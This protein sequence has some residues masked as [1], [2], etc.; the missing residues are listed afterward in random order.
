LQSRIPQNS[1]KAF[2]APVEV[3]QVKLQLD[4][5]GRSN[6]KGYVEFANEEDMKAAKAKNGCVRLA[7]LA[8]CFVCRRLSCPPHVYFWNPRGWLRDKRDCHALTFW[9]LAHVGLIEGA[10]ALWL[11]PFL[12]LSFHQQS[13]CGQAIDGPAVY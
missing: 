8:A 11:S 4:E 1:I 12:S 3:M 10:V 13:W 5:M 9:P 6:G 7:F 2:F